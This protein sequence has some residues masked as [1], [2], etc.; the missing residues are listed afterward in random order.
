MKEGKKRKRRKRERDREKELK[1]CCLEKKY[2]GILPLAILS[3][4]EI[5]KGKC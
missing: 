3:S 4:K 2:Q 5:L 1:P